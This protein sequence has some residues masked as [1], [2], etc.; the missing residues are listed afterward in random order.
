MGLLAMVTKQFLQQNLA[1]DVHPSPP[2]TFKGKAALLFPIYLFIYLLS[3]GTKKPTGFLS[4]TLVSE[5]VTSSAFRWNVFNRH[6]R[7][8]TELTII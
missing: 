2:Q 4:E 5:N 1:T 8:L 6:F 3:F 7:H